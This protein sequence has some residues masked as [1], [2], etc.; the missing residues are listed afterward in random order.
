[1]GLFKKL[2]G[3][4]NPEQDNSSEEK[5]EYSFIE[6][7]EISQEECHKYMD[8]CIMQMREASDEIDLLNREYD[9]VPSHINDMD[10][11][12]RLPEHIHAPI[13]DCAKKI[14]KMEK[15]RTRFLGV[16]GRMKD[17][18]FAHMERIAKEMPEGYE[19]LAQ[20]EEYQKKIRSDLNYLGNEKQAYIYRR[21]EL[22]N[23]MANLRGISII[24]IVAAIM[25]FLMLFVLYFTFEMDVRIGYVLTS[26]AAAATFFIVYFKNTDCRKQLKKIDITYSKLI[27]MHNATKIRYVNNTGLLEYYYLK[28]GVDSSKELK[29]MWEQYL[30]EKSERER[31]ENTINDL[32]LYRDELLRRISKCP[33]SDPGIWIHQSEALIDHNEMVEIRHALIERRQN[34]RKQMDENR[35]YASNA[36]ERLKQF[37]RIYPQYSAEVMKRVEAFE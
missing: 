25:C 33:V 11:I 4:K 27:H 29:S 12:E 34:L 8:E 16:E 18:D 23:T 3:K 20:T 6:S 5:W 24:C 14:S 21:N 9:I 7:G 35:K 22:K 2:F 30:K 28:F 37:V 19:K 1:M 32:P 13:V 10:E 36:L 17:S 15:E 26:A 31:Y